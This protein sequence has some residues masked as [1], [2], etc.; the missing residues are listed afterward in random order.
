V[1][2]SIN[3]RRQFFRLVL[4]FGLFYFGWASCVT[5][6]VTDVPFF[7]PSIV[8]LI[9]LFH[10]ITQQNRMGEIILILSL[11]VFGTAVDSAFA[12]SGIIKYRNGY[13]DLPFIAPLWV[14]SMWALF[15]MCVNHSFDWLKGRWAA[16]ALVGVWGGVVSY[17]AANRAGAAEFFPDVT[18]VLVIVGLVWGFVLPL[19]LLYSRFIHKYLKI[20]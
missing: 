2:K 18:S 8:L 5:G 6:A 10:L 16:A 12:R 17:F 15:G 1:I 13:Q 7:G 14:T 11:A 19:S 4:N 3:D 9:I 20:K